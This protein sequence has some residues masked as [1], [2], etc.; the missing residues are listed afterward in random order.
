MKP[1]IQEFPT[2]NPSIGMI[3][4]CMRA[5]IAS[6]FELPISSV[7]HIASD[8]WPDIKAIDRAVINFVK[9]RGF[10]L[11][12][13]DYPKY[14]SHL[15]WQKENFGVDCYHL[16]TGVDHDGEPHVC[17]GKNGKIIHDPHPLHRCF[18]N[19]EDE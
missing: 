16:I 14:S 18:A 11:N 19:P 12:Q 2:H 17:V 5:A 8:Y 3:G 10:L 6:I 9:D 4:D 15:A 1:Q 13:F 7:P